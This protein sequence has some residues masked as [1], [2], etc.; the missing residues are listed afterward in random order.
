MHRSIYKREKQFWSCDHSVRY[1]TYRPHTLHCTQSRA[2][3]GVQYDPSASDSTAPQTLHVFE[4][5]RTLPST[6]GST[7]PNSNTM[8]LGAIEGN[9]TLEPL[10]SP[11]THLNSCDT[12]L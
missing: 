5:N 7:V 12:T 9:R 3:F 10:L 6:S 11:K 4:C 8:S 1:V 2:V